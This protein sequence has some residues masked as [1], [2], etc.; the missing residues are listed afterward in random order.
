MLHDS[1]ASDLAK[2]IARSLFRDD[3]GRRVAFLIQH[4]FDGDEGEGHCE[5]RI[6]EKIDRVLVANEIVAAKNVAGE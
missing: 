4:D 3:H 1:D 2:K 5:A 6:A